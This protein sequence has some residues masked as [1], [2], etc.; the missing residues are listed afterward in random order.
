[1]AG[2]EWNSMGCGDSADEWSCVQRLGQ[3]AADA[4]FRTHWQTWITAEDLQEIKSYGLN[5]VR[6]PVGFWIKE[7]LVN[8]G[9]YYPRGGLEYLDYI[10]GNCTELGFYVIM[11]LHGGPGSQFPGQQYT[12]HVVSSPGFYTGDN[13]E[14][15]YKFLE[16]MTERVHT[17]PAYFNVGMLQVINEPVHAGDYP[18]EAANMIANYYPGA[19]KRIRDREAQL[20]V[21]DSDKLH[22][23]FMVGL[24][25]TKTGN[26][27]I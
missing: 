27:E 16:W 23:Q 11:D 13:Y 26:L 25:M 1:M 18:S 17:N 7:D 6:I 10:V 15:A 5:T 21:A 24:Q 9:E 12:G 19:W 8:A 22:I 2:D 14:R 20:G 4:A 3:D